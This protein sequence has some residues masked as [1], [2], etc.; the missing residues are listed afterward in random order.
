M[1]FTLAVKAI[2]VAL[3][4]G[5]LALLETGR[6]LGLRARTRLPGGSLGFTAVE[7]AVFGLLGLLL[8]F[9]F[10][11]AAS[12][13]DARRELVGREANHIGTAWLRLE[14]LPPPAQPAL[15][16]L[17]R[18]YLDARL[19]TY[20][21]LPDMKAVAAEWERSTALSRQI[22]TQAV[23]A[24]QDSGYPPAALLLLPALNE[25]I[26]ITTTRLVASWMHPPPV[27]FG[28]LLALALAGALLAGFEMAAAARMWLH[29]L[30]F[31]LATSAAVFVILELEYPRLGWIR[32]DPVDRVLVDLRA[33]MG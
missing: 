18:S 12:H 33:R 3:L 1:A 4:L 9:T 7:G 23:A 22:W 16:E 13:F 15:R 32:V 21:K 25:M 8:A 26:D 2:A 11:G 19:A 10:S 5:M 28:M 6:R 17:F 24:C 31:G 14:L 30:A 20:R 29:M 27:V